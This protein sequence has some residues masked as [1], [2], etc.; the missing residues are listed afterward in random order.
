MIQYDPRH[1]W[2]VPAEDG[3][4]QGTLLSDRIRLYI[5]AVHLIEP[6]T[7]LADSLR[8]ASY[9]LHVGDEYYL[10]RDKEDEQVFLHGDEQFE[11]PRNGLVYVATRECFNIPY[12]MVARYSLQVTQVYRGLLIENGLQVD[13]GYHGR[14]FVAVHNLTDEPRAL[15]RGQRFLSMDFT[16]T[17]PLPASV[18]GVTTERHLISL[19]SKG[20]LSGA[21]GNPILLFTKEFKKL[22]GKGSTPRTF[23][24]RNPGEH[25]KSSL[26]GLEERNEKFRSETKSENER[27]RTETK[28]ETQNM[29]REVEAKVERIQNIS[30]VSIIAIIVALLAAVLPWISG[31]YLETERAVRPLNEKVN[32][33]ER[34]LEEKQ[35]AEAKRLEERIEKLESEV[36]GLQSTRAPIAAPMTP[37]SK[38]SSGDQKHP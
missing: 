4:A 16:L 18:D 19:A 30:L 21:D 10:C 22:G 28:V 15:V 6:E 24:A 32:F 34:R 35:S 38:K 14:I 3:G 23:W 27:F 5:R 37:S 12:Y 9:D 8:P 36:H 20:K 29:R 33:L 2:Q 7:F 11:I 13:P 25:H 26:L 31:R 1:M 17:T